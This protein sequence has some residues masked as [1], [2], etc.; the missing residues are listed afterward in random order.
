MPYFPIQTIPEKD[1][2]KPEWGAQHLDFA[3][4]LL[5][6]K[7]T[8]NTS[9]SQTFRRYNGEVDVNDVF[10]QNF[11]HTHGIKNK[12]DIIHY[13][14]ARNK[15]NLLLGEYLKRPIKAT[16]F[17]ENADAKT[18]KLE[19]MN[20]MYGLAA[21]REAVEKLKEVG[22]DV[23]NGAQIPQSADDPAWQNMSFKD[24]YE[25]IMQI[26]INNTISEQDLLSK[27]S[28]N[29]LGVCLNA[30]CYHKI[31]VNEFTGAVNFM[32]IDIRD[33]I[34]VEIENDPFLE[35]SPLKGAKIRKTISEV[36]KDT[37]LTKDQRSALE[38]AKSQN[39]YYTY[40]GQ[41]KQIATYMRG[42][43]L[44]VDVIHIEWISPTPEY[45]ILSPKT[46]TQIE[47]APESKYYLLPLKTS[48]YE[49]KP[50]KYV[51]VNP[52]DSEFEKKLAEV[53]K[54]KI[55][56]VVKYRDVI[57]E[58]TRI[59]GCIDVRV[60][61]KPFITRKV[62]SPSEACNMSYGG[63]LFGTVDGVRISVFN[64]I[65][66]IN[67]ALDIVLYQILKELN[68]AK[69]RSL[70]IDGANLPKDTSAKQ[71]V[72]DLVNDGVT[73]IDSAADGNSGAPVDIRTIIQQYDL[74]FSQ[75]LQSLFI[76]KDQ[77]LGMMDRLSGINDNRE[78]YSPASE[79][80]TNNTAAIT[81]S[82]TATEPLF[83]GFSKYI[84]KVLMNLAE[85]Q[86]ITFGIFNQEKGR[87]ILGDNEFGFLEILREIAYQSYGVSIHDS[88]KYATMQQSLDQAMGFALNSG[89]IE[90]ID[91]LNAKMAE[92]F[93]QSKNVFESAMKRTQE[94][95][96]QQQQ[97]EAQQQ[98]QMM[99]MQQQSQSDEAAKARQEK[100]LG[101]IEKID[102]KARATVAVKD[103]E[104][105]N[106]MHID[107]NKAALESL[108]KK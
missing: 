87:Q 59:A 32:P 107:S 47:Y 77:L 61:P 28:F 83:Y 104:A 39:S 78:G 105:I 21:A 1:K 58:A 17:T 38:K 92:T 15:I 46:K 37:T 20:M 74:G 82:R 84:E 79:T 45:F 4:T 97:Q 35:R 80:A 19:Y 11:S 34:F 14:F 13:N 102:A 96:A 69:G 40:A 88:A 16:V 24:K 70:V 6:N 90:M 42:G 89:K 60:R 27:T 57:W 53:D 10:Y 52:E 7:G 36:L 31:D 29:F 98:Q 2:L 54:N 5:Q 101:D 43:D 68:T 33:S 18:A 85:T 94:I 23:T 99:Q 93:V 30:M 67:R 75:N 108:N 12:A 62:D 25:T 56:C 76:L 48:V 103:K 26:I 64:Q 8:R 63:F 3:V 49:D 51:L 106:K 44:C 81:A 100:H 41:S 91:W 95:A 72:Y 86:K 22:V 9:V 55:P 66:N 65:D 50:D 73:L 71:F